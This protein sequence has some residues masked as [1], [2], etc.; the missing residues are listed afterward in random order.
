MRVALAL[1]EARSLALAG[2]GAMLAHGFVDRLT[3]DVDLFTDRDNG[4]ALAVVA[5]LRKA[6]AE[7]GLTVSDS[8]VP[9]QAH[10]F[11]AGDPATGRSCAVDVFADGG[12]LRD[13]AVLDVGPALHADD[14]VAD[15]VLALWGRAR[16][17]DCV[18]VAALLSRFGPRRLLELAAE[19]D[20]GFTIT[21]FVEALGAIGR[22]TP[23]DWA[24]DEV[25][26]ATAAASRRLL[27]EWR[28]RL[29]PGDSGPTKF[30]G[31]QPSPPTIH[32]LPGIGG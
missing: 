16:P 5:A 11:V 9:P 22:L 13:R 29:R 3:K 1:P 8:P 25:P 32:Q 27:A 12:R 14:L 15:K 21:T 28:D 31:A 2:G 24:D 4:E 18:D 10:R 20:S 17:R 30:A 23:D 6:L 7:A 19:K 26:P